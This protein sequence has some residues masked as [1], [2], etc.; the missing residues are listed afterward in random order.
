M[1]PEH[2]SE[3]FRL[4][5]YTPSDLHAMCVALGNRDVEF[6]CAT[7]A[8][9]LG[10]VEKID[11]RAL[12]SY[13]RV[14]TEPYS[15]GEIV[16]GLAMRNC[17]DSDFR[18]LVLQ[19]AQGVKWDSEQYVRMKAYFALPRTVDCT[20]E[21]KALLRKGYRSD[22][23]TVRDAVLVAAQE[24]FGI[25]FTDIQWG[26]GDDGLPGKMPAELLAWLGIPEA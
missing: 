1:T 17:N 25:D 21:I 7:V 6:V 19:F 3:R 26:T 10:Y 8:S 13:A 9:Y 12:V 18:E 2:I 23:V 20:A 11:L 5:R 16:S 4:R 14:V 22:N 24:Y 15:V